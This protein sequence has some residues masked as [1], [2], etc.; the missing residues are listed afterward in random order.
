HDDFT[1][2]ASITP[3]GSASQGTATTHTLTLNGRVNANDT[4]TLSRDGAALARTP[5]TAF[6]TDASAV[7]SDFVTKASAASGYTAFALGSVVYITKLAGGTWASSVAIARD[8]NAPNALVSG[9]LASKY[10]HDLD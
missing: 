5:I 3:A 4:G 7:V 9:T 2:T 8:P 6:S 1:A 10:S